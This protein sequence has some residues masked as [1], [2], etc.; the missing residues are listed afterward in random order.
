[1]NVWWQQLGVVAVGGALG[2][3]LRFVL[4]DALLRQFG[5]GFP[6]GTLAANFIGAFTAGYVLVWLHARG[7]DTR[8][9][10]AFLVVGLLGGLTTFSALMLETLVFAR[11][12]RAGMAPLYLGMSIAG[13]LLLVWLGARVAEWSR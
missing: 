4:G 9:L 5:Q 11:E 2:S 6:W 12:G 1:M 8:V 13:G 10:R 7:G 3:M